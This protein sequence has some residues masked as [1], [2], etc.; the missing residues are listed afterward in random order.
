M[1]ILK[2]VTICLIFTV[3]FSDLLAQSA[4]QL[5][6]EDFNTPTTSFSL[7]STGFGSNIG[8]NQWI[9]NNEYDGMGIKPNTTS[10]D[11]TYGGTIFLAPNSSY[12]HI[13]DSL[14]SSSVSNCNY[15]NTI[16]SDRFMEM[17]D[18]ICTKGITGVEMSFFY[19]A[20]GTSSA[21]GEVYYHT[22]SGSWTKIGASKYNQKNK[23]KYEVIS[24]P[25]FD[26]VDNLRFGFRWVNSAM[27]GSDSIAKVTT[28]AK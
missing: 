11:S 1:Q 6:T 13:H 27:P 24:N 23:W 14:I 5:F 18:G 10:Q 15:D 8:S 28:V 4:V 20:E 2:K 16:V 25:A 17:S 12:A 22:G 19:L 3:F 9:I 26:N 7:N 21:Y